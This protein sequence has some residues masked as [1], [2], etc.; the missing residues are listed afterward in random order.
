MVK[1]N[2][3]RKTTKYSAKRNPIFRRINSKSLVA[4]KRRT[5]LVKLIKDI[6]VKQSERKY[7]TKSTPTGALYHNQVYQF[8]LWGPTGT[9]LD[10]LPSQGVTDGQRL[11]DRI[12]LEGFM[13]RGL[14]QVP[15]DRRNTQINLYFVPHNSEQGNPSSD[16]FHNVT[17]STMVD[18]IQKKR[19]PKAIWLGKYR[20]KPSDM[21]EKTTAAWG[22]ATNSPCIYVQKFITFNK[23]VYFNADASIKPSNLSEYGTICVC[24]YQGWSALA[25]DN[26]VINAD[27][28]AT[29]YFRDL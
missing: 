13:I 20:V 24:P 27:L 23:K 11:G 17:G 16:L 2:R 3:S 22:D 18:P 19:Y 15:G 25:T 1:T 9:T 28:N 6:N 8:H 29:A 5:N 21:L 14:F 12:M 4:K 10:C 26:I 7:L